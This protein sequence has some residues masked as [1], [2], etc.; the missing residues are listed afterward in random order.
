VWIH[1]RH[2]IPSW[3]R[4]LVCL[5]R[6]ADRVIVLQDF[7]QPEPRISTPG[8]LFEPRTWPEQASLS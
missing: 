5:P 8:T 7:D 1:G 2:P 6:P 3:E 4:C